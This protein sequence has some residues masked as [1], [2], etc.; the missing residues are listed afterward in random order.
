MLVVANY[1]FRRSLT[2]NWSTSNYLQLGKLQFQSCFLDTD[3]IREKSLLFQ[4]QFQ[5]RRQLC[6]AS[7]DSDED[8]L[9][10]QVPECLQVFC[11]CSP[12]ETVCVV[13]VSLAL[14]Y[15]VWCQ[16]GWWN[17][18][19]SSRRSQQTQWNQTLHLIFL[20]K[21]ISN[22]NRIVL[23]NIYDSALWRSQDCFS[24]MW[25]FRR[26]WGGDIVRRYRPLL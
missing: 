22:L 5:L 21:H 11:G 6:I 20:L 25:L 19:Y 26:S 2:V 1:F 15:L 14:S 13:S 9:L 17:D 12:H 16:A 10:L 24:V 7:I 8:H 23:W 18:G 3:G 4:G